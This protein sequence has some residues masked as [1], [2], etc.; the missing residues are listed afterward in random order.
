[1]EPVNEKETLR[2]IVVGVDGSARSQTAL[3]WAVEQATLRGAPLRVVHAVDAVENYASGRRIVELATTAARA[4]EPGL[5]V[6]CAT[7]M[8]SARAALIEEAKDAEL[9]VLARPA[10]GGQSRVVSH[11]AS[12][13][14][15]TVVLVAEPVETTV[16]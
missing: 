5:A 12:H 16:G 2:P 4:I 1:M 8:K 15:C 3:R 6:R 7:P 9:L 14:P 10:R 13:A 11:L